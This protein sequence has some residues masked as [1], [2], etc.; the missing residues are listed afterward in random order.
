MDTYVYVDGF[1][2][3]YGAFGRERGWSSSGF[4]WLDLAALAA[5]VWP[6]LA[7]IR[8]VRYFTARVKAPGSDPH[9]AARQ[10][11]YLR[12]LRAVG[13]EIHLGTFKLRRKHVKLNG[14]PPQLPPYTSSIVLSAEAEI[15]KYDEKGSD[16][17]LATYLLRDVAK[18]DCS[19]AIV[20]SN[21]SDL[22]EPIR[23]ARADFAADVYVIN[24]QRRAVVELTRA[25]NDAR[26]LSLSTLAACQ[27]PAVLTDRVGKIT[28]PAGW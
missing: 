3:Y 6:G 20:V 2:L 11:T 21:D 17:N 19:R 26:D 14:L 22:L 25:A 28:R 12:A 5:H 9:M 16:V 1:N 4:K 10:Q 15:G 7:P 24:P 27:L 13:V 8:H 18:G 23:V